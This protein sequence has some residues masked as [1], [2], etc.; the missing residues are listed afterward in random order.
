MGYVSISKREGTFYFIRRTQKKHLANV[1]IRKVFYNGAGMG[2]KGVFLFYKNTSSFLF[3]RTGES[4]PANSPEDK[5]HD[6][7]NKSHNP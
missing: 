4:K 6:N 3:L 7:G 1:V 5:K 2:Q